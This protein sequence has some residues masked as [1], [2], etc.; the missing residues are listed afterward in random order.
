MQPS[1]ETR[2]ECI[3]RHT[4]AMQ[5]KGRHKMGAFAVEAVMHYHSTVPEAAR[6][7]DFIVGS[8]GD[9]VARARQYWQQLQRWIDTE[10][11]TRMPVDFEESWVAALAEPFRSDC[12]RDLAA[13]YKLA[14]VSLPDGQSSP[15]CDMVKVATL[16]RGQ[17]GVIDA[18]A[19][20]V[21][22]GVID[23]EDASHAPAALEAID[24]QL[25]KLLTMKARI[26]AATGIR[27]AKSA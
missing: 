5:F 12:I 16:M 17:S 9:Y 4:Q 6:T 21:E 7:V 26:K 25:E 18:I 19:P 15:G 10:F 24:R 14:A 23:A 2:S 11:T 8:D 22:N 13:R 27:L 20:M 3:W 1:H